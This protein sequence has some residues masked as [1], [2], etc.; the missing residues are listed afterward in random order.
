MW[1]AVGIEQD[2]Q[3]G[4]EAQCDDRCSTFSILL[5][6]SFTQWEAAR[7]EKGEFQDDASQ[8]TRRQN[9]KVGCLRPNLHQRFVCAQRQKLSISHFGCGPPQSSK[10]RNTKNRRHNDTNSSASFHQ[11]FLCMHVSIASTFHQMF[12][13]VQNRIASSIS[14]RASTTEAQR[15]A[16]TQRKYNESQRTSNSCTSRTS[17]SNSTSSSTTDARSPIWC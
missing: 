8:P 14:L 13:R 4:F 1:V 9:V 16:G 6:M 15:K 10:K 3:L 12:P 11:M 2:E 5:P 7:T 17:A